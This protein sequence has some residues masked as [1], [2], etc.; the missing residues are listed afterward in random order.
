MSRTVLAALL[1]L[2]PGCLF[3]F[4]GLSPQ[5]TVTTEAG[6][7]RIIASP[8]EPDEQRRVERAVNAATKN[9]LRWGKLEVPVK[10]YLLPSHLRLTSAVNGFGYDWLRAWARYDEVLLQSPATWGWQVT[11]GEIDELL[12]H[13][14]THCVMYQRI[15]DATTWETKQV[16]VWFREGMA[17]WT[18]NQTYKFPSLEDLARF[19]EQ[20]PSLDPILDPGPM[21]RDSSAMVY[22]A[23]HHGF[24]FFI[25]RLQP[26]AVDALLD[27]MKA[28]QTFPAAFLSVTGISA[29]AFARE[30][31]H[32]IEWRGFRGIGK[33]SLI[34]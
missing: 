19:Y 17:T 2:G 29:E 7:V 13:E 9:L 18:A 24:T 4:A 32:Y 14:L 15:G 6:E 23:A 26:H 31:R 30:F 11:D 8:S 28:G 27:A 22:A 1:C 5:A 20:N 12:L 10:L 3:P 34:R 16:P 25:R 33:P 21:Y